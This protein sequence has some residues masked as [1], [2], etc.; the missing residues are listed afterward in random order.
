MSEY[1][2]AEP[3]TERAKQA[4]AETAGT[5]KQ[6]AREV[7]GEVRAQ[8]GAAVDHLRE[9]MRGEADSQSRRA[10]Q[11]L[12][13]WSDDLHTMTESGTPD[14]PVHG[15]VKQ[16]AQGGRKAADYID[17]RGFAGLADDLQRF[18][19]RRPGLFLAGALAAGFLAG[20]AAKA[21][22]K[23]TQEE[24]QKP[25][26]GDFYRQSEYE[27]QRQTRPIDT[28]TTPASTEPRPGEPGYLST[29]PQG[30]PQGGMP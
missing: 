9:R 26:R 10:A 22:A 8:T 1:S 29:P 30:P 18:A 23:L 7:T 17:E 19:R 21:G 24:S 20:R 12:R 14:S 2:T 3:T 5:A 11:S 28:T 16:V 15:V 27:D 13:Q 6:Q 25:G 4:A